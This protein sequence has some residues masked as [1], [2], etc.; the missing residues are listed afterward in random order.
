MFPVFLIGYSIVRFILE[1]AR[2]TPKNLL[3][4]SNGQLFSLIG[5]LLGVVLY[6]YF[7]NRLKK[8]A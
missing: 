5:I 3:L 6:L 4:L 1:F 2:K 8:R 7:S